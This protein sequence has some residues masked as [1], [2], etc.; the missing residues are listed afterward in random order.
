MKATSRLMYAI[1]ALVMVLVSIREFVEVEPEGALRYKW[2][3]KDSR[4]AEVR[5]AQASY[6]KA[7]S[8]EL[9]PCAAQSVAQ[10]ETA[11]AA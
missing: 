10:G 6:H 9:P 4:T 5:L 8:A 3:V 2:V 11:L 1:V 7:T